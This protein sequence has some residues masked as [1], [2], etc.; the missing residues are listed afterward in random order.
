MFKRVA[1]SF[2]EFGAHVVSVSGIILV[3]EGLHWTITR[4]LGERILL[5]VL[6][7][8][9]VFQAAEVVIL[10]ALAF[11]GVRA[12]IIAYSAGSEATSALISRALRTTSLMMRLAL[13][14]SAK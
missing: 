6:P 3:L 4:V 8:D 13:F 11:F 1:A 2:L 10:V 5:G 9:R 7:V 12:T 14:I